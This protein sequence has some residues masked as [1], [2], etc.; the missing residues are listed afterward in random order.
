M[1][2]NIK[3]YLAIILNKN[4]GTTRHNCPRRAAEEPHE[5]HV[6]CAMATAHVHFYH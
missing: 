2:L 4:I 5:P 6:H 3:T 1:Q